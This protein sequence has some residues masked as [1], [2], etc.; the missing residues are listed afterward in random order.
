MGWELIALS[1]LFTAL[2]SANIFLIGFLISGVLVDYKE[3]EKIPGEIASSLETITDECSIIVKNKNADLAKECKV[4]L[5][6]LTGSIIDWF[7][8][9]ERTTNLLQKI[10]KLNEYFAGFEPLTQANFIVRMKQEQSTIRR[11][12]N[13][14]HSIRETSF[15]RNGYTISELI[16]IVL[17]VGLVFAKV[18]PF[19]ES[20]FFI[21]F[22]PF[23][24]IYMI[25]LIKDLDNPF[26]YYSKGKEETDEVS[27]KVLSDL[28]DR[29]K[30][31]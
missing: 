22:I 7:Y 9:K 19:Y 30:I 5:I 6:E 2:I 12:M 20:V 29:M 4:Y 8:K 17:I 11:F 18:E 15:N 14:A 21:V 26:D 31:V 23:V 3:A 1:P 13:R 24:M 16:T 27:I 25:L 10:G 28:K